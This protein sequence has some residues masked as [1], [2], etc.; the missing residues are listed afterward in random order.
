MSVSQ[1]DCM[2]CFTEASKKESVSGYQFSDGFASVL[3]RRTCC[4]LKRQLLTLDTIL[5]GRW[6]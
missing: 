1:F 4:L 2:R 6:G 5:E 3:P